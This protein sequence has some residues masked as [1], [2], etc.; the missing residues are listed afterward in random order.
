VYIYNLRLLHLLLINIER[1]SLE[2]GNYMFCY[3][4]GSQIP[5]NARFCPFCGE[6]LDKIASPPEKI[7]LTDTIVPES[8]LLVSIGGGGN[9]IITTQ[10]IR[11]EITLFIENLSSSPIY[12]VH[13]QLNG[14]SHVYIPPITKKFRV[15]GAHTTK[16]AKITIMPKELGNFTLDAK[17]SYGID[18]SMVIPFKLQVR[19][20][21]VPYQEQFNAASKP[22]TS[23]S[24]IAIAFIFGITALMLVGF[25]ISMVF[26]STSVGITMIVIGIII[27]SIATQGKCFLCFMAC[28]GCDGCDG[29]DCDC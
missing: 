3:K 1:N 4:C 7:S 18:N 6:I 14:P 10:Y 24:F 5:D 28:D 25:G 20:T 13:L 16:R 11:K 19:S 23:G 21:H 2:K 12:D 29:C 9:E 27:F 17:V 22:T 15:I 26:T 8:G